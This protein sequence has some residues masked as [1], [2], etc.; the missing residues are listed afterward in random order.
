MLGYVP[1]CRRV[2]KHIQG[3]KIRKMYSCIIPISQSRSIEKIA[4]RSHHRQYILLTD[5]TYFIHKEKRNE[6]TRVGF[7]AFA[8]LYPLCGCE[9]ISTG[10]SRT[11]IVTCIHAVVYTTFLSLLSYFPSDVNFSQCL[12]FPI[13]YLMLF[14]HILGQKF[15]VD[16]PQ[17]YTLL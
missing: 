3:R 10:Q 9:L 1:V 12:S 2:E 17:V 16:F 15:K 4:T 5:T 6:I 11:R 14:V 13:E 7:I 8:T